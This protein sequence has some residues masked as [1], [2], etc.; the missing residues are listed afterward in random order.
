[1]LIQLMAV[2]LVKYAPTN[3]ELMYF[4]MQRRLTDAAHSKRGFTSSMLMFFC[5][6]R[7]GSIC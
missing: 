5:L 7:Q 1:M 2:V 6:L 4:D 3:S